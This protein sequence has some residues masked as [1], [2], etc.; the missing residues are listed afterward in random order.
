MTG[1]KKAALALLVLM[2]MLGGTT[3]AEETVVQ[4]APAAADAQAAGSDIFA[5]DAALTIT[6][7]NH[8]S[9]LAA[10]KSLMLNV[11]FANPEKIN[12]EAENDGIVW[13]IMR[14][15]GTAYTGSSVTISQEGKVTTSAKMSKA[16]D[17]VFVATSTQF[18]TEA[19]YPLLV[20]PRVKSIAVKP[21]RPVLYVGGE[22]L[23][24]TA[25]TTPAGLSRVL[26]WKVSNS[27]VAKIQ[28]NADGSIYLVPR[29]EGKT[30]LTVSFGTG[31]SQ[32]VYVTVAKPAT[33]VVIVGEDSV[34][35]GEGVVLTGKVY[36]RDIQNKDVKWSLD[37]DSSIATIDSR[38][39]LKPTSKCPVGTVITVTCTA[40][41]TDKNVYATKKITVAYARQ[42]LK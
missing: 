12:R 38:G 25:A 30:S 20:Y 10:G 14:A 18:G 3:L 28:R 2:L 23:K 33:K 37:V 6:A 19:E 4:T 1:W 34:R 41:G 5:E 40:K 7:N 8:P 21:H 24:I 22:P 16:T 26:K 39:R 15:D 31:V 29:K 27:M 11:A 17:V 32:V 35:L 42:K 9:T 13:R 36:P